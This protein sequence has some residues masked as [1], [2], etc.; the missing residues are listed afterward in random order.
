M[1]AA[2]P[3]HRVEE[4]ILHTILRTIL[5][6]VRAPS[7]VDIVVAAGIRGNGDGPACSLV[8]KRCY[9]EK[10]KTQEKAIQQPKIPPQSR[11]RE[12]NRAVRQAG[13]Y[14]AIEGA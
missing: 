5:H 1:R 10:D 11:P 13:K 3:V 9:Y 6:T 7:V 4:A 2:H 8:L 12:G 14:A